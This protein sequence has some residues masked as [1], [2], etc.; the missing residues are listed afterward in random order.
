M[1]VFPFRGSQ[2]EES[3]KFER[4]ISSIFYVGKGSNARPF[5]HLSQAKKRIVEETD[6]RKVSAHP[7][8]DSSFAIAS[9]RPHVASRP[10]EMLG[11][12]ETRVKNVAL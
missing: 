6:E 7:A 2:K 4:F 9:A 5:S 1:C 11:P 10:M 12:V 8:T 3:E